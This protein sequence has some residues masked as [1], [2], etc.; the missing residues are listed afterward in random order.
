MYNFENVMHIVKT[1][2]QIPYGI[3]MATSVRV[4]NALGAGNIEQAKK[5]MILAFLITGIFLIK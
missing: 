1:F 2:L 3:G 5:S 4:G